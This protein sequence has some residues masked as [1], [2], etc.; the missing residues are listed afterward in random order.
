MIGAPL[1]WQ[2]MQDPSRSWAVRISAFSDVARSFQ[3]L[4]GVPARSSL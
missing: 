2:A 1:T 3:L 4:V